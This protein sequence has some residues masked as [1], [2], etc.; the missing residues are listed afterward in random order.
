MSKRDLIYNDDFREYQK[1][2]ER[3]L[4]DHVRNLHKILYEPSSGLDKESDL[5]MRLNTQR[6]LIAEVETIINLPAS[7]YIEKPEDKKAL[8]QKKSAGFVE[9]FKNIFVNS[10]VA[11]D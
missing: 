5:L 11:E 8:L 3:R 10:E 6:A 4:Y 9:L 2:L 7:I 1:D